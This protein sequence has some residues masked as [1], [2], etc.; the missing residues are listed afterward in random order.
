M[1]NEPAMALPELK[2]I[3]E[4]VIRRA[5]NQGFVV[6]REIREELTGAGIS[7]K[8][9]KDVLALAQS[10]LHFRQ[11][12][13]YYISA[14]NSPA[15]NEQNQ[16][17][18]IHRAV[19][20]MLQQYKVQTTEVERRQHGRSHFVQPT[21][22]ITSDHRELQVLS[23]DLSPTGIR[24]IGTRSLQGQKIRV[25]I[26]RIGAEG[27]PWCFLVQILWSSQIGDNLIENG[28]VFLERLDPNQLTI[29][30]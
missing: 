26:P 12:R 28:G 2:E 25:L 15:R 4:S 23:R 9:W 29:V 27:N 22:V 7:E 11:G 3:A 20:E 16:Q 30:D 21:K 19:R 13:Y 14:A 10:S 8:H 18:D 17:R 6:S 5:R 24:L 1:E